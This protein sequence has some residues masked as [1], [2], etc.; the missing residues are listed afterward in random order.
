VIFVAAENSNKFSKIRFWKEKSVEDVIT[1]GATPQATLVQMNERMYRTI[2][3]MLVITGN[4][5]MT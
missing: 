4:W 2:L 5:L 1:P 3:D